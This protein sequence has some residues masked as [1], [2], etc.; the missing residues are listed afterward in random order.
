MA[1]AH[2]ADRE[3]TSRAQHGADGQKDAH[4]GTEL[5]HLHAQQL[6][7]VPDVAEVVEHDRLR[8]R[9]AEPT[10]RVR[11]HSGVCFRRAQQA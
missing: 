11:A 7:Q 8:L 3:D 4:A 10:K 9:A 1:Q 5:Q 2:L 6:P